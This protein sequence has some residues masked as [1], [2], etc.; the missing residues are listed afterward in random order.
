MIVL[1]AFP[2]RFLNAGAVA[3]LSLAAASSA[4][5]SDTSHIT[6]QVNRMNVHAFFLQ[7]VKNVQSVPSVSEST[8]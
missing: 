4:Y 6:T 2:L 3:C 8:V 7:G 5:A 1:N